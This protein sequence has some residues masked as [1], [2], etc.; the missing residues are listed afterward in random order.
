M[1]HAALNAIKLYLDA[2]RGAALR[3]LSALVQE[4]VA[5]V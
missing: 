4:Q 1:E 5:S 3:R 2:G